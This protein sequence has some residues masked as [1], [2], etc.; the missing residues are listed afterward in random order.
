M[1]PAVTVPDSSDRAPS[2]TKI[3]SSPT[4]RWSG[5]CAPGAKR[6]I[7]ARRFVA[8]S[9]QR[10]LKLMP[11]RN[12]CQ[13]SSPMEM[14]CDRGPVVVIVPCPF[15]LRE[16][17]YL[18]LRLLQPEVH[19]HLAVHRRRGGE[20]LLG[21]Y[22]LACAPVQF[23][24]AEVAIRVVLVSER[25][26]EERHDAVAHHLVHSALVVTRHE[27]PTL[28]GASS[29]VKPRARCAGSCRRPRA[30]CRARRGCWS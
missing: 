6:V 23:A 5:S 22:T 3:S 27:G 30:R 19:V 25:R 1:F 2:I 8:L 21:R 12:S 7:W 15:V 29:R 20:V 18:R 17:G 11:G 4:C 28:V 13:P 10:I 26:P 9:S 14:I 16:R 24:E